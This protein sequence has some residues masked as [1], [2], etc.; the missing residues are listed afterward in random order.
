M[1]AVDVLYVGKE[2]KQLEA[3]DAGLVHDAND[4]TALYV[5]AT[6]SYWEREV[7]P[8]LKRIPCRQLAKAVG[9]SERTIKRIRN[10][11]QKPSRAVL[12][13]LTRYLHGSS[14]RRLENRID[15]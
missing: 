2:S 15:D 5:D 8:V 14:V 13:A 3:V 7:L 6:D 1:R 9:V 10:R 12:A 4:V 11:H